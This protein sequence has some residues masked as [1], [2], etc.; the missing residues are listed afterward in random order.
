MLVR[1]IR[2][3]GPKCTWKESVSPCPQP[4]L[5]GVLFGGA[6]TWSS[7]SVWMC[8][9]VYLMFLFKDPGE[10]IR[11][12]WSSPLSPVMHPP[13]R[14]I[15]WFCKRIN[16]TLPKQGTQ[17]YR[18]FQLNLM[19]ICTY[20]TR[21]LIHT[22]SLVQIHDFCKIIRILWVPQFVWIHTNYLPLTP[23]LNFPLIGV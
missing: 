23:P 21:L 6:G 11:A 4:R 22:T 14:W 1:I 19:A 8:I 9:W 18:H 20:F 10:K 16:S 17:S 5:T 15:V 13:W 12:G 2:S 7:C 3:E